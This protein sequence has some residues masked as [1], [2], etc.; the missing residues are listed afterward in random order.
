MSHDTLMGIWYG[1]FAIS[2]LDLVV[3][4]LTRSW[5]DTR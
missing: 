1:V 2:V 3:R 5:K 4:F